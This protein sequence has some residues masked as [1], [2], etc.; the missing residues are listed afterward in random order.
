[1]AVIALD[2]GRWGFPTRCYVCEPSNDAGL[3]VPFVYDDESKLVQA[4]FTLGA[5]YSGAPKYVHGGVV[6]A[7]LD[8]AMAW[9]AIAAAGRFAVVRETTTTFEH[10]IRVGERHR[11]EAEVDTVGPIR[12]S[13]TARVL[14]GTGRRCARARSRLVILSQ[15]GATAAIGLVEGDDTE[16]L[17]KE[18]PTP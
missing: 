9:A 6:L 18:K 8:E 12:M 13:A 10:G 1:M 17:R 15:Q 5:E 3:R 16:F 11:V 7:L 4:D 14:D 2:P